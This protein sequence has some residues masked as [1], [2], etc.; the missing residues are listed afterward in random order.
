MKKLKSKFLK[1]H[2]Y[3]S[4]FF[5][6][7]AMF[8]KI[9]GIIGIFQYFGEQT[10]KIVEFTPKQKDFFNFLTHTQ[11]SYSNEQL[12]DI[13]TKILAFLIDNHIEIPYTTGIKLSWDNKKFVLGGSSK[14][15][16]IERHNPQNLVIY[17]RDLLSNLM[18]LHFARGGIVFNILAFCFVVFLL[19][20]Y[21]TGLLLCNFSKHKIKYGSIIALG[22]LVTIIAIILSSL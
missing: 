10:S 8:Y 7:M 22:F 17:T 19:I 6:P 12:Q 4:L 16:E 15:I 21:I 5:I 1:L 11:T 3:I 20:T 18:N 9:T 14:Y 13:R 2:L